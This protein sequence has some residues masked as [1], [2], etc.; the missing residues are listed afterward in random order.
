MIRK[1]L[2]LLV[3]IAI[4]LVLAFLDVK[5]GKII[6]PEFFGLVLAALMLPLVLAKTFIKSFGRWLEKK[7]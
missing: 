6:E 5:L 3:V 2:I 7:L 4:C 1:D